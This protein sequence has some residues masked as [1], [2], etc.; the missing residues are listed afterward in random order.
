MLTRLSRHIRKYFA[1]QADHDW[2][3]LAIRT[4]HSCYL[5]GWF[6]FSG[7][8]I[9]GWVENTLD[10]Q[11]Q[12]LT[13]AVVHGREVIASA[14]VE[15]KS[16][17]AGWR[18]DIG[19]G[20]EFCG[21]DILYDRVRVLVC[22][23]AGETQALRLEGSTQLGLIRELITD[24]L[25]PFLEIDFRA[26]GN[27]NAFLIEG[28]SGQEKIHRWTDGAQ[29]TLAFPA[30]PCNCSYVLQLLLWPFIVP[31]ALAEQRL[32]VLV[33]ET[34]I[35]DFRVARQSFLSCT[36]PGAMLPGRGDV[37]VRFLHPDATSPASLGVRDDFRSLGLAFKMIKVVPVASGD[38]NLKPTGLLSY[39][40]TNGQN[41][42]AGLLFGAP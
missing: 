21:T 37:T 26:G 32:R 19:T 33:N 15:G 24:R 13:V 22:D 7:D 12:R 3:D 17:A 5:T 2:S 27:S 6:D 20:S 41:P 30:P 16:S 36:V 1:V 4:H 31:G 10:P 42:S 23:S 38:P 14:R 25:P 39:H 8:R 28:W 11:D 9:T 40:E 35:A 34:E 29:S 18:F